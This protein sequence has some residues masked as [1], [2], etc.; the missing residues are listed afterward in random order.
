M[1]LE[2]MSCETRTVST[3]LQTDSEAEGTPILSKE[4]TALLKKK[5]RMSD[6]AAKDYR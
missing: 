6:T 5:S 2:R 3:L 1:N 4:M